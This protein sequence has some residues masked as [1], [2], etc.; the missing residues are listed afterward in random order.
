[1]SGAQFT[2]VLNFNTHVTFEYIKL[3]I[4]NLICSFTTFQRDSSTG[5]KP[6]N[7][8]LATCNLK[9]LQFIMVLAVAAVPCFFSI[10]NA[11]N[12]RFV[13]SVRWPTHLFEICRAVVWEDVKFIYDVAFSALTLLVGWQEGHPAFKKLSGGMLAWLSVWVEMQICISPSWCHWHSVSL[14][15]VNRDWSVSYTHLTLPTNREV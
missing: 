8:P 2:Y 6:L 9:Q 1:M 14:V 11:A 10:V 4:S 12:V 15:T 3:S 5:T 13:P 7:M